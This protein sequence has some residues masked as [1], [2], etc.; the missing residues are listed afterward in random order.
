ML[1]CPKCTIDY[2]EG[3]KFCKNCG[4][5]L[6][7]REK[8]S[9]PEEK[10]LG[11][12]EA[13]VEVKKTISPNKYC[14]FC[15]IEYPPD[16]KFCK[17]CGGI[18]TD[19]VTDFPKVESE[20]TPI[21]KVEPSTLSQTAF[22]EP[23]K[24]TKKYCPS[25]GSEQ[26]IDQKFCKNCGFSLMAKPATEPSKQTVPKPSPGFKFT[27]ATPEPTKE[28]ALG[29]PS[30]SRIRTLIRK[31]KNL[32][33]GG[34]KVN[35]LISNL[36]AQ[37][38]IISEEALNVTL[39]PYEA[40]LEAIEKEISGI[41]NYLN[42]LQ[43][44]MVSESDNLERELRPYKNRLEELKTM[45]KVKG[46]TAGDYR[47]LKR[48]P[49][50]GHKHL[51]AEINERQ[52]IIKTLTS[53]ASPMSFI[54]D[55]SLS[56]KIGILVLFVVV[57]GV[58]GFF[59]YKYIFIKDKDLNVAATQSGNSPALSTPA[60]SGSAVSSEEEIRKVFENI[61]QANMTKDINLFLS[62]YS[63]AFPNM[64]EKKDNTLQTWKDMDITAL[65]YTMR[66]LISQ[67]NSAEVTVDWQITFRSADS[68]KA[69][70]FNTTNK[71]V[72]QREGG[73]WKIV[74]LK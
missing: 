53:P 52:H 32:L 69:E 5:P 61:K 11:T 19:I 55:Q 71:V 13:V 43:T 21:Q 39:K 25:C 33:K 46:L 29:I 31:K 73:Q 54:L 2:P 44:K 20:A 3:K 35:L 1:Y 9:P 17:N 41:D 12:L 36:N 62:C 40:K 50:R 37:R 64:E 22:E 14:S 10:T 24:K 72:L 48:E 66:D 57:L 16:K 59:G 42:N 23:T 4:S 60:P 15:G 8:L 70:T 68:G 34:A 28:K 56:I 30:S 45:K 38:N 49:H 27:S 65:S 47:R 51:V 18:L 63:T 26:G 58:L 7:V 67:Q 6:L 74:D